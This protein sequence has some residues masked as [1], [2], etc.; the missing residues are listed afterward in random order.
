MI[1]TNDLIGLE[2]GWGH[3]PGDGSNKTDCFQLACEV[4]RRLGYFDY[5]PAFSWVYT[6]YTDETFKRINLARWLLENGKRHRYAQLGSVVLLPTDVGAALGTY[7][8]CETVLFIGPTHNVVKA[9]LPAKTGHL[10][11]MER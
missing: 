1:N 4:H 5:S 11:W 9:A 10:F 7:L 8:D 2:Y 6:Q 3:R